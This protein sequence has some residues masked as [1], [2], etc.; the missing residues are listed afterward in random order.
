MQDQ[1]QGRQPNDHDA[2]E[3]EHDFARRWP[4]A[5]ALFYPALHQLQEAV[6]QQ[7]AALFEERFEGL[8]KACNSCHA[9][10]NVPTF[11][12]GIPTEPRSSITIRWETTC[13]PEFQWAKSVTA[14]R[15]G[16]WRGSS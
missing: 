16:R 9:A 10:E 2:E 5:R 13:R 3:R 7:N 8:R 6:Q 12:V 11:Q 15:S 14:R 4:W 1:G